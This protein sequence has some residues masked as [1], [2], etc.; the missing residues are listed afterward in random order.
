MET[1]YYN[2]MPL[3]NE[4]ARQLIKSQDLEFIPTNEHSD[5]CNCDECV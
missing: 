5:Y 4:E 3:T 2:G 1:A